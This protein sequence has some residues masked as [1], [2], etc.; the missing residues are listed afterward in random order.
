MKRRTMQSA[1]CNCA[2]IYNALIVKLPI[3]SPWWWTLMADR[4]IMFVYTCCLVVAKNSCHLSPPRVCCFL[5]PWISKLLLVN[6]E[7]YYYI[8]TV[9]P[10]KFASSSWV[11]ILLFDT[12]TIIYNIYIMQLQNQ[13]CPFPLFRFHTLFIARAWRMQLVQK[14][15]LKPSSRGPINCCR[16]LKSLSLLILSNDSS[17]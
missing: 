10:P 15:N 12:T 11:L 17:G 13:M 2:W 3:P 16:L 4:L 5:P 7:G 6:S 14:K 8:R 9:R 1:P